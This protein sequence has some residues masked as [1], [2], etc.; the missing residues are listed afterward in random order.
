MARPNKRDAVSEMTKVVP[1]LQFGGQFQGG[2]R[3]AFVWLKKTADETE[4]QAM[5]IEFEKQQR[6][7]KAAAALGK[8]LEVSGLAQKKLDELLDEANKHFSDKE[9]TYRAKESNLG[10]TISITDFGVTIA[11]RLDFD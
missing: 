11:V 10:A 3:E 9:P 1:M 7:K 4:I 8:F 5:Y 6:T 2:N